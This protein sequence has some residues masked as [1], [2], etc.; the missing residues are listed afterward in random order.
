MKGQHDKKGVGE[1]LGTEFHRTNTLGRLENATPI[2]NRTISSPPPS[3]HNRRYTNIW[4]TVARRAEGLLLFIEQSRF[5]IRKKR[6]QERKKKR[7]KKK[8]AFDRF[9]NVALISVG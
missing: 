4:F 8:S 7:R 1:L 5:R 2:R 9:Q 6:P 3:K